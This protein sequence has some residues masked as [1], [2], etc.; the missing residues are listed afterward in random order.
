MNTL[1]NGIFCAS[2]F[3]NTNNL[4]FTDSCNRSAK[5]GAVIGLLLG[6]TM[7]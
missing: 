3:R 1:Q 7:K 5:P 6:S 2:L 4:F